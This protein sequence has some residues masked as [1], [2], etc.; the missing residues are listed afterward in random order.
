M[1]ARAGAAQDARGA[2]GIW[3][4][5]FTDAQ[6]ER[7]KVVFQA[8][9]VSCHGHDGEAPELAADPFMRSWEGHT[10]DRL[11]V[12]IRDFMPADS[13][14]S[15]S[16]LQKLDVMTHILREN[17]FPSGAQE[18][19]ADSGTLARILIVP[20]G[21]V[22][23]LRTGAMVQ[24]VGCLAPGGATVWLL[25]SA[26]EPAVTTSDPQTPAELK[27]LE[28]QRLGTQT[29]RLLNVFPSADAHTGHRV[30]V[31]GFLIRQGEDVAVNV[32]LLKPAAPS[33]P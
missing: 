2:R 16:P 26:T 3:D 5:V 11:Y 29:I 20:R 28:S 7:G 12:K 17:G 24:V 27:A 1:N 15:I 4:G 33:C 30:A 6:A 23:A 22:A 31:K 18:L 10:L 19:T 13:V 14:Q 32:V 25:T 8:R 21:G 9:C